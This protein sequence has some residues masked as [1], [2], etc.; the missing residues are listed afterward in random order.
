MK[1]WRARFGRSDD[2]KAPQRSESTAVKASP[3]NTLSTLGVGPVADVDSR[4]A[5]F[6]RHRSVSV[7]VWFGVANK[8]ARGTASDGVRQSRV[9]GMPVVETRQRLGESDIVQ[10]A[11]ADE[12]G[13]GRG[14]VVVSLSNETDV[15]AI[16]AV[17]VRP[18]AILGNGRIDEVRSAGTLL[19]VDKVP[20]VELGREPGDTIGAVDTDSATPAI[21]ARLELSD[22]ELI[23]D[24][25]FTDPNG[26]VSFAALVPLTPGVERQIQILD[27]REAATVAPAP[28]DNI[29]S[30]WRS[31]LS[32]GAEIELPAWP[33]HI[34]PALMSS[35]LGAAADERRPLGDADWAP[36]DDTVLAAAL[37]GVGL[38]WA[39]STVADRLLT[40]VTEGYFD[41]SR[42]TDLAAALCHIAGTGPGDE[43]LARHGEAVAAVAGHTLSDA[44]SEV[45]VPRLLRVVHAAH[46]PESAADASELRGQMK[47]WE[48]GLAFARHGLTVPAQSARDVEETLATASKPFDAEVI[49]L[50]M[51]ASANFD[52][53]FEPLVPLRSLAGSTWRWPRGACG[54]SP[55]ARAALLVGLRSL[56]I[57][58]LPGNAAD[59]PI[60]ATSPIEVDL[61]PGIQRS[62]LGQNMQFSRLPTSVGRLSVALRWHGER[63]A[64]LWEVDEPTGPFTLFCGRID[65]TFATSEP[66][67]EALLIA[68]DLARFG[69][70][71]ASSL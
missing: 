8:W 5:I 2:T 13:D 67:G 16:A 55:H 63:A 4:G 7:E 21:L 6:P 40:A 64:L 44:R 46:G 22:S 15:A 26:A 30:G 1:T 32:T 70:G 33:K 51:T 61:F 52:Y 50:A 66:S 12:A 31:H 29:V 24:D 60:T 19:I 58:E 71:G 59:A 35:L 45:I 17:V 47:R 3:W 18:R 43:V 34:P 53:S 9:V 11:W 56:C 20:L 65:P 10:T 42:W 49:G 27:G 54:D 37:G 25:T 23:G 36:E 38:D 48:D 69:E 62:W 14:R 57:A 41:R 28:L 68:P 39:A